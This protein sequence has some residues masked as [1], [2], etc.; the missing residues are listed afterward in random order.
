MHQIQVGPK[1]PRKAIVSDKPQFSQR[2]LSWKEGFS[3]YIQVFIGSNK[4]FENQSAVERLF[5]MHRKIDSP[6]NSKSNTDE[7]F[8]QV[9]TY[10]A[11]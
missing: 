10:T 4:N 1:S 7:D 2:F 9:H 3:C 6:K 5:F 11:L 8:F